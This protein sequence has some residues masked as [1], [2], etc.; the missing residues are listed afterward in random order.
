MWTAKIRLGGQSFAWRTGHF[1]GL[2]VLWLMQNQWNF[3]NTN[4]WAVSWQNQMICVPSE[5]SDQ[6]GHPPSLIRVFAVCLKKA[7]VLSY[8]LSAH[9]VGFVML[10]LNF[11]LQCSTWC[12]DNVYCWI[13]AVAWQNQQVA[14]RATIAHL[15][16]MCQGPSHFKKHINGPW[17]PEARN[18]NHPSFYACPGYQQLWWR[19]DQKWMS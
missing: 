10:R 14:Q 8:L 17:K 18:Q 19:F 4:S 1:V 15:S 7:W 2:L 6:P 9:F 12:Y 3:F 5:V 11:Y 16:P 13:W